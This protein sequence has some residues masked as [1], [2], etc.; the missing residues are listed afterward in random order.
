MS[1]SKPLVI[2]LSRNY[3]TGLGVIR[4]LGSAGYTVDLIASVKKNGS[5]VIASCSKYV[6]KSVEVLSRKI[7]GDSGEGIIRE[8]MKYA[9]SG[10]RIVLFPADDYTASIVADNYDALSKHFLIP[11]TVGERPIPLHKAMDKSRQS[12]LARECGIST[13]SEWVIDLRG[14]II[15]PDDIIYPCFVKPAQSINGSKSEMRVCSDRGELSEHL[16][17]M[18][19]FFSDRE[20]IVQ[21]YL[22]IDMEY[23]LSGLCLDEKIIIPGVIEKTRISKHEQGVTMSGVM[24]DAEILGD[25]RQKLENML[26]SL[27]YFGMFDMELFVCGDMLY[28][29]EINLRSGG[30]N[31]AYYLC[32]VNLPD[33]LVKELIGEGHSEAEER[34]NAFGKS[35]VYEKVAWEDYIHSH[36]SRYELNKCIEDADFT[37]LA[38]KNDPAPGRSFYKRI[39][40][41]AV[42]HRALMA[43]GRE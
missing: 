41:S 40:L 31:Y 1:S 18:K 21:E 43:L 37:L 9:G 13:I 42:K 7:Q 8:L 14:D 33:I 6:R 24:L 29:N 30:P 12:E 3:S 28:F 10:E 11:A 16:G 34:L 26:R 5:S 19:L 39:R 2:V 23:D 4:S 35:F 15:I 17:A 25:S 27:H 36:M 20:I 32:G 22:D 38:D